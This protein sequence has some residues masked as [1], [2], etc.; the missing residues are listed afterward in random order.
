VASTQRVFPEWGIP[1][2]LAD[3]SILGRELGGGDKALCLPGDGMGKRG[4]MKKSTVRSVSCVKSGLEESGKTRGGEWVIHICK[5]L[6]GRVICEKVWGWGRM[7]RQNR[8]EGRQEK[9]SR[10]EPRCGT[11]AYITLK[12]FDGWV[13]VVAEEGSPMSWG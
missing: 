3:C 13:W 10:C 6:S 9:Y 12:S 8:F 5:L 4:R 7:W 1:R 2:P 11:I